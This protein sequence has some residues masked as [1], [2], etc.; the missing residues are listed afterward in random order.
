MNF[1]DR[2]LIETRNLIAMHWQYTRF[3]FP[4]QSAQVGQFTAW[5]DRTHV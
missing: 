4:L 1:S 2:G 3:P 5:Q